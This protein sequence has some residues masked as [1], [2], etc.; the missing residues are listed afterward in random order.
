MMNRESQDWLVLEH[1]LLLLLLREMVHLRDN[2]LR[3][4]TTCTSVISTVHD[5]VSRCPR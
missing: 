5:P 2:L 4:E 3:D 1:G